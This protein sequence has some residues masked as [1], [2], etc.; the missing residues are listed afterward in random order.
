[1]ASRTKWGDGPLVFLETETTK[2]KGEAENILE[3]WVDV[4]SWKKE[5]HTLE[6]ATA[7]A[8]EIHEY[9][10]RLDGEYKSDYVTAVLAPFSSL[11]K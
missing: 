11:K 9:T 8:A 10:K 3:Y 2:W 4:T 6:E 1:M 5:E 7:E